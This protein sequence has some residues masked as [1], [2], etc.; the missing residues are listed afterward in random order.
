MTLYTIVHICGH[1]SERVEYART[2]DDEDDPYEDDT[3]TQRLG[4]DLCWPCKQGKYNAI[5]EQ[6]AAYAREQGW[7]E[8]VG[9][10]KQIAWAETLRRDGIEQATREV[11]AIDPGNRRLHDL[12]VRIMLDEIQ[13][14]WWIDRRKAIQVW[15]RVPWLSF[16]NRA[17][18][19]PEWVEACAPTGQRNIFDEIELDLENAE[20]HSELAEVMLRAEV[21]L[22]S[23]RLTAAQMQSVM[24][25]AIH[26]GLR[27]D[28]EWGS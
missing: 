15:P 14:T 19:Y 9:S 12:T 20:E 8:L 1:T 7:P 22:A 27:L 17:Q 2:E 26:V 16:F 4:K 13:A 23:G 18:V 5:N 6:A 28:A 11:R 21:A 10:P 24:E 3:G 25:N